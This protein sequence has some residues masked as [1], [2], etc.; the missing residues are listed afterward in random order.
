MLLVSSEAPTV[1][2]P[3]LPLE[4]ELLSVPRGPLGSAPPVGYRA[5]GSLGI[6]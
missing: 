1:V 5:I 2:V 6:E 3:L 4:A